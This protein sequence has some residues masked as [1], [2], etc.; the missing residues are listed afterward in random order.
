MIAQSTTWRDIQ[1]IDAKKRG[2]QAV[3]K[4]AG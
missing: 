1:A 3:S 2:P 4:P